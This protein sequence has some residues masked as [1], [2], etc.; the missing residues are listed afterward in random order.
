MTVAVMPAD[1][2]TAL[3]AAAGYSPVDVDAVVVADV[4]VGADDALESYPR[5]AGLNWLAWSDFGC[6]PGS[7]ISG[8]FRCCHHFRLRQY[9]R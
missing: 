4:D 8:D 2:G 9:L 1:R 7:A 5:E 3:H 6:G